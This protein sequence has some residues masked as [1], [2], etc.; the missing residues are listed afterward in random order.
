MKANAYKRLIRAARAALCQSTASGYK[1]RAQP[2]YAWFTVTSEGGCSVDIRY[3]SAD[4]Y[5]MGFKVGNSGCRF[6]DADNYIIAGGTVTSLELV[7]AYPPA[8]RLTA[9]TIT[10]ADVEAVINSL[11]GRITSLNE[12]QKLTMLVAFAEAIRFEDVMNAV[13]KSEAIDMARLDWA[14]RCHSDKK[15]DDDVK[16][17]IR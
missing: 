16:V 11:Y 2:A 13:I 7:A 15:V 5:I 8:T 1:P 9:Q 10:L 6:E 14:R 12:N 4:L 3:R 17:L